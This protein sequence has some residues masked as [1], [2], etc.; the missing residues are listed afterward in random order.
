MPGLG[1]SPVL[2]GA[3]TLPVDRAVFDAHPE[4]LTHPHLG[5]PADDIPVPVGTPVYAV[6]SGQILAI[7]TV[8]S[9]CGN[10]IVLA[11]NDGYRYT[12]CHG[13]QLQNDRALHTCPLMGN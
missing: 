9:D 11:G 7:T 6:T 1:G 12:Y 10:G 8:G 3:Y 4:Y 13:S 5:F 2:A